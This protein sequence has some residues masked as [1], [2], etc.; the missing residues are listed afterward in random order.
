MGYAGRY[1]GYIGHYM[2][3]VGHYVGYMGM[4][5]LYGARNYRGYTHGIN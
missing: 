3:Y 5:R 4:S 2:G 1:V